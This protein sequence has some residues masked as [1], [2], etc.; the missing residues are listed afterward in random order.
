MAPRLDRRQALAALLG[1]P[2]AL[3]GCTRGPGIGGAGTTAG[4]TAGSSAVPSGSATQAPPDP[5]IAAA[6]IRE[7][8]LAA[9]AAAVLSGSAQSKLRSGQR[10]LLAAVRDAHLAHVA[11]LRSP[12]PTA[13]PT[14]P[15][16]GTPAA[17]PSFGKLPLAKAL[18]ALVAGER[19]AA[20]AGRASAL[21]SSGFLALLH[22]SISV[23]AGWHAAGLARK[24]GL[25]VAKA[26]APQGLPTLSDTDAVADVVAQLHALVY[27]YQLALGKL[28]VVSKRHQRALAELSS[29]RSL[30]DRLIAILDSRKVEVPVPEPAYVPAV[31]VHD[32]ASAARSILLMRSALLPYC[33]LFL[34]AADSA[35]DR[36][37]AFDTLAGAASVARTWGAPLPTWPGW[38]S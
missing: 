31:R 14:S 8:T 27:G 13:R 32:G 19:A 37:L 36:T 2:L 30:R 21:R 1:L 29:A 5:L 35:A 17:D 16:S 11:A 33:G 10:A 15:P 3:S 9:Q 22:G 23:A 6:A 4:A 28:P 18:R 12:D 38:P 24:N 20:A 34:A 26:A 25:P 7:Q